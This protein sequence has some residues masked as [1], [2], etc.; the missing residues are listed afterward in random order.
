MLQRFAADAGYVREQWVVGCCK[1]GPDPISHPHAFLLPPS[2]SNFCHYFWLWADTQWL[3]AE[4]AC[5]PGI[6]L[7]GGMRLPS[8]HVLKLSLGTYACLC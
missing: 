6:A 7:Q 4:L 1:H 2:F 3:A 8:L 5:C